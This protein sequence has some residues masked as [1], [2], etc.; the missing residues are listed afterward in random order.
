[1][2]KKLVAVVVAGLLTASTARAQEANVTLYGR[3]NVDMEVVNGRQAGLGCP[4]HCP[5]PNVFR[6]SSNSSEFGIRGAEPLGSGISAT[7][8]IENSVSV[9]QGRGVLAGR[10]TYVGLYGPLGTF[11]MGYFLGPYD[12]IL[13]LF[14]N[15]PMLTTSIAATSSLWAQGF[16]GP[17]EAGGFDD[18]LHESIRYDTPTVSGLTA[19]FQ[20]ASYNGSTNPHSNAISTGAF[21]NNGPVQLGVAY[22]YHDRIRGTP[23]A[24]LSDRAFSVA[25]GYQ[26]STFRIGAVYERLNYDATPTSSLKRNL[27][28]VSTTVDIG[29]GLLYAYVGRAGNG[30]GT[31]ANGTRIGGLTKGTASGSTQWEATYTYVLS[32]RTLVYGG[33][34][35]IR[36]ESNAAYTFNH[37]AYPILC[38]AYPNG[39]CGKP[40]GFL[41]GM[42][43]FF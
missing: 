43:H 42:A 10:D 21:Y 6:V 15:V 18:R 13:P 28:G 40:G 1:L 7:F 3:L 25:G 23:E 16:L 38:D 4:D 39:N 26:F 32:G 5:N 19:S 14:G 36:N 35:K 12:D 31:A 27:F 29:G 24:P 41:V 17:P 2:G 33:Y 11:K 37:N 8:Q 9:T 20:F 22:E 30:T 34:V